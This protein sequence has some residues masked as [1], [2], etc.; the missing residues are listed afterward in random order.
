MLANVRDVLTSWNNSQRCPSDW[1]ISPGL[2]EVVGGL[3]NPHLDF[4]SGQ[5]G[6][7]KVESF[8]VSFIEDAYSV[9]A[10]PKL[11]N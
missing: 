5:T 7:F 3:L 4:F 8:S 1:K 9:S 10:L 6:D 2:R 11:P